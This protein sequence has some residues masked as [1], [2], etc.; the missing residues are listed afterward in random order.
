MPAANPLARVS[1][2][3]HATAIDDFPDMWVAVMDGEVIAA[4][5][6]SH[7]LAITLH[8]MDHRRRR[9]VVVQYV[10]PIGDSY[11]VGVG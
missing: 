4:E 8:D 9:N 5:P 7:R 1:P 6:T 2:L 10:R 3:P 11:I